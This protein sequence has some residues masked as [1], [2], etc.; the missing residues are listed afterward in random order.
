MKKFSL[1]FLEKELEEKYQSEAEIEKIQRLSFIVKIELY[2]SIL[3]TSYYAIKYADIE[4]AMSLGVVVLIMI[5]LYLIKMFFPKII[6]FCLISLIFG[7][8]VLFTE[9]IHSSK[10]MNGF[11][12]EAMALTVP[13][14]LFTYAVLLTKT[15]WLFCVFYYCF[16]TIYMLLRVFDYS[17]WSNKDIIILGFAFSILSFGY[18]SYKQEK[19]FREFY[20]SISDSDKSLTHFKLLVQNIMPNPIFIVDYAKSKVEFYNKSAFEMINT[21]K[22]FIDEND[23]ICMPSYKFINITTQQRKLS[24]FFLSYEKL[25]NTFVKVENSK[26]IL[27]GTVSEILL[28]Y[29]QSDNVQ[30]IDQYNIFKSNN[31]IKFLTINIVTEN[32]ELDTRKPLEDEE[33]QTIN[34]DTKKNLELKIAKIYWENKPCLLVLLADNT[35][36]RK[37]IELQ[38]LDEYKNRLLATVSHDLRTPLNGLIGIFEVVIPQI[39]E[40]EIKK[41]LTIGL[42]S[43][44]LLLYMINDIL[45]FSQI[46]HK[47]I[48]L[49]LE[50]VVIQDILNETSELIEF[51]ARKKNLKFHVKY[52]NLGDQQILYT[53]GNRIKQI[54]LNLLSNSLKFT[55]NGFIKLSV[56]DCSDRFM[57][58]TLKF[59]VSD[60]GIGIKESDRSKLFK[61]FGKLE[62]IDKTL[63]KTWIGLGLTISQSL[64]KL[65][66]GKDGGINLK[67]EYGHGSKFWFYVKSMENE[68]ENVFSI[69]ESLKIKVPFHKSYSNN[70]HE[71]EAIISTQNLD[72]KEKKVLIVDDDL[73]NVMIAQK[74]MEFFGLKYLTA[75]NGEE[76]FQIV[77]KDVLNKEYEINLILMDCNMPVLDGFQASRKILE[78][79]KRSGLQ[80][81]PIIAVTANVEVADQEKCFEAGMKKFL[82]KPVRRK[83]LGIVLQNFLKITLN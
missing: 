18:M 16:G 7:F 10:N 69:P 22:T 34:F 5:F 45:D 58:P 63:N 8:T 46:I 61:L 2:F 75:T 39:S 13:L 50:S 33:G 17:D 38:N 81:L 11:T 40:Q 80:E 57:S 27:P 43:A 44:N 51:Q 6:K 49:N 20:K 30:N 74:Y 56:K 21:K 67:S 12:E 79:L 31:N 24:D 72:F 78:F 73:I 66:L 54:L 42:R 29:Y 28:N 77:K 48:R 1:Q 47:K 83:E 9:N 59:S 14:Q 35:N 82:T 65:L 25:L 60:S 37:V 55:Q 53:D 36:L 68:E 26:E 71:S 62:Q 23:P 52:H 70:I 19:T 64:A 76:A 41:N 32:M 4:S 15:S 3:C